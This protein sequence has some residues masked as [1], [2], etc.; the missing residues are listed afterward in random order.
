MK[1]LFLTWLLAAFAGAA[2]AANPMTDGHKL[3]SLWKKWEEASKADLPKEEAEI[4]SQIKAEAIEKHLP[5]DFYDA[6]TLYVST[7]QR[8]DWKQRDALRQQ[9]QKEVE[10]FGDPIVSFLWMKD[11]ASYTSDYIWHCVKKDID[12]FQGC[13]PALHR[14]VDSYLGGAL[15]RFIANDKEYVLWRLL[16]NRSYQSIEKDEI[17]LA[18]KEEVAG[19][20]PSEPA[21][22][23]V[24]LSSRYYSWEKR[25]QQIEDYS[26]LAGKY[27]GKAISVFPKATVLRLRFE[28][29]EEQKAPET[30]FKTLYEDAQAL[31]KERVAYKGDEGILA[32]G[33]AYP[34]SLC[35]TLTKSNLWVELDDDDVIVTFRN[36][37][38]AT[39]TLYKD[40]KKQNS[41][42]IENKTCSFY[43]KDTVRMKKPQLADGEY[44]Y[45]AV[46]G[47]YHDV[48][49]YTQYTL[50]IATRT[51]SRGQCVFIA[52]Y[53]T[54]KPLPSATVSLMKGDKKLGSSTMKLDGFTPLPSALVRQI[55]DDNA[56]YQ[57]VASFGDKKSQ[58]VS[59]VRDWNYGNGGGVRCNVY[60]D[61]GAYNPGDTLK[62]KAVV[63][64]GN[65]M[66]KLKV[67]EGKELKVKFY[68]S[69]Y[70]LLE[71]QELK[72]NEF[73][74]VSGA[75]AIPT[76][77]RNGMFRMEV[78]NL[79][80]AS[81]R[82]DEFVLPSFDLSFDKWEKLYLPGDVVPIS[83]KLESYSGHNLTGAI[84]SLKLS[85]YDTVVFEG[86]QEVEKDNC[87]SFHVPVAN[88]GYY[89]AE[90]KVTDPTG[91][92]LEFDHSYY[93][94]DDI[95]VSVTVQNR[96]D[97]EIRLP[98]DEGVR[99]YRHNGNYT[100][101]IESK[102]LSFVPKAVSSDGRAVPNPVSYTIRRKDG[103]VFSK[104]QVPS[105]ETV[106]VNLPDEG[107]YILNCSVSAIDV[108]GN[109]IKG[110]ETF[111][112]YCAPDGSKT[113]TK[114][115]ARLFVA[116]PLTVADGM[117]ITARLGS[118]EGIAYAVLTVYGKDG[119]VLITKRLNVR[120]GEID[121]ISVPYASTWPDAVRMQVFYFMKGGDVSFERQYRREKT[122]LSLPLS[123][124][125]FHSS[126]YPGTEYT[127][128]LKAQP[129]VEALAAAW[130]KSLDAIASN[131]WATVSMRDYSVS[132]VSINSQCGYVSNDYPRGNDRVFYSVRS[133]NAVAKG[134]LL[135]EAP[136]MEMAVAESASA[137]MVEE[138]AVFEEAPQEEE[139]KLRS[140]FSSALTFQPH[141]LSAGDGTVTFSFRT[142]DKLSTYYVRV[143]AHGKD[144]RNAI[145]ED[146]M[147]VSLPVKVSLLEPRF[148]Y[149]GDVYEA[150]LTLSS[151]SE[152]PV[153]GTLILRAGD[154]EQQIPVTVEPGATTTHRF[155]VP[156]PVIPGS[157]SVTP[158]SDSVI[159]GSDR[160]SPRELTLTAIFKASD[161]SDAVQVK[162]PVLPAAQLLTEAHSAVL[163]AGEDREALLKE[164]RSRF[165]N[166]P[167]SEAALKEITVLDMVRDAIPSHVNPSGHDVLSLSEAW[168]IRL[169]AGRIGSRDTSSETITDEELIEKIMACRNG[170]GGFGW[171]EGMSSSP[172]ITA[173]L[174]ERFAKLR[175]RGFTVPDLSSSARYLDKVQFSGS[176]PYWRGYLSD[177]QYL[178]VRAMYPKVGF[179]VTPVTKADKKRMSEFKKWAADY[180]TPSK[181]DGRGL[182]GQ[183]LAKARRLLTLNDL[184]TREGGLA[185]AKSWGVDA[186]S[187]KLQKSL[188]ADVASLE[189][190]AVEHR[191][192]GWYYP[193]AVMPW[194]G[195]LESEAYAHSLLAD[196]LTT[197]SDS[198]TDAS[199]IAD[200]V[201]LWLMLQKETQHWD[202]EPAYIDAITTILDGSEAV[203]DTRVL[204]LSA[205]YKAPFAA[206]KASGNG[207]TVERKFFREVTTEVLYDDKTSDKN[208]NKTVLQEIKPGDKVAVGDKIIAKYVIWNAENRSFVRLGAG[209]EAT[210]RPVDQLSG[211][212]GW[213]IRPVGGYSWG[214]TPQGYRDVKSSSTEY[215]F[216]SY[217]EEKTEIREEFFVTQAGTFVAPV[218]VI[219]SLYA[220]HYRANS[221]FRGELVS[222]AR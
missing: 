205:T 218:T 180:L 45:E 197:V 179:D 58:P 5:E 34:S 162:V 200:G 207:F 124:T 117:P 171:F 193:N 120:D 64:E 19:R 118:A 163:H 48:A 77:L 26:A 36:L 46:N 185:L 61:R 14:G 96:A 102:E 115:A 55:K 101:V 119:E 8:R 24:A 87:F 189:Q 72:T 221:A 111:R 62:F 38:K 155:T 187:A 183:I 84:V 39:V 140:V 106:K 135:R 199:T 42:K 94:S 40:G 186:S 188:K 219:E 201:R 203:L 130:D 100:Q 54:G 175:D 89:S 28:I 156:V 20:Y 52:D 220:P 57:L 41:K 21:L 213:R 167:A 59:L 71:T 29:L 148:L 82:V 43:V 169:M 168:Y 97:A 110:D 161:F 151:M 107:L 206:I 92:T 25:K 144:M 31:E 210:L 145:A 138:E 1:R 177:E 150:A 190:Y 37:D 17:Y 113:L 50:S 66:L 181:K 121:K 182:K 73:G 166:V 27:E 13:H 109:T 158:G 32:N 116:G 18:L 56:Y 51:D 125:R 160:E 131:Y 204:A 53:H 222:S 143:Y 154:S 141:L 136:V 108:K 104:G 95:S 33:T 4:L 10:A 74:S 196:L 123:F 98:D 146:E 60:R 142:S 47:D 216:D 128:T 172:M 7:V 11:H 198:G 159:P 78:E 30:D 195:L 91:E 99:Y 9:L 149:E 170:D 202:T 83:G 129:G 67:C 65:P 211:Y 63:Y 147:I 152:V 88:A 112:I 208:D 122:R 191:D 173:V 15:K 3:T 93:V 70:N 212:R 23:F 192:G 22:E 134:A 2:F 16:P 174:L 165:V 139:V 105:G 90:V 114:E 69:E 132:H 6:A 86:E 194:R 214:F 215:Y 76:G 81:F 80:S 85:L 133:G 153:S 35:Q 164:L 176:L 217:P 127:F 12:K 209:R 103:E 157:S 49:A 79:A 178:R 137:D 126:A 44:T 68:D 75:F 184:I